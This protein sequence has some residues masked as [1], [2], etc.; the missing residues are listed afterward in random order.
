MWTD[1]THCFTVTECV[2]DGTHCYVVMECVD[3]HHTSLCCD[4]VC[5]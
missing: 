2:T 1:I 3:C 5:D 4:G